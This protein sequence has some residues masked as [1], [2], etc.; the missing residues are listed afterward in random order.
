MPED[1]SGVKAF[2]VVLGALFALRLLFGFVAFPLKLA[3][4]LSVVNSAVFM[5][6][7]VF[8]MFRAGSTQWQPKAALGFVTVGVGLH[9][10]GAVLARYA[11]G[12]GSSAEVLYMA[13]VQ[14]GILCWTL[15][16]GSLLAIGVRDKNLLLPIAIFLIGA[17]MFLVFNP[18]SPTRRML[19]S[20]PNVTQN[21]LAT[22]PAAKSSEAPK[23]G[24]Q[25]LA[26]VGPADLLFAA[27]FFTLLFKFQMR[28][29][30]TVAWL[31][32]VLVLYLLLV[33]QF[34]SVHLG[35]VSLSMLPAMVPIGLTVLLVNAREFKLQGQEVLGVLLVSLLA[36]SLAAFGLYRAKQAGIT[37]PALRAAPSQSGAGQAGPAPSGSP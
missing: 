10:L 5:G 11:S 35:P 19:A 29:K 24:V 15:G 31:A 16:L 21:V 23:A 20:A 33:I 4:Y 1:R 28:P 34:G 8:A 2:L 22:V 37:Q 30:Q 17:D 9:V 3:Q 27:A 18:D 7:F 6:L 25:D 12:P 13:V 26:Q 32:P 14:S 36:V